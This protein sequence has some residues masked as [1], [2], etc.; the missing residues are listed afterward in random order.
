MIERLIQANAVA[1][2]ESLK[3]RVSKPRRPRLWHQK[4]E[5]ERYAILMAEMRDSRAEQEI[6]A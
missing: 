5:E 1:Q 6:A 4:S 2:P 3:R